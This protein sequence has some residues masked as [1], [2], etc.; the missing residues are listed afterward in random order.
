MIE[1]F[2]LIRPLDVELEITF[3]NHKFY[4]YSSQMLD[5]RFSS[6]RLIKVNL[7]STTTARCACCRTLPDFT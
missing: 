2:Y 5:F 3:D 1:V 6:C 7:Q 4:T